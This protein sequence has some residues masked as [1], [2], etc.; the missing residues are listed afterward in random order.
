VLAQVQEDV[1]AKDSTDSQTDMLMIRPSSSNTLM[2]VA[3][4]SSVRN[5]HTKPGAASAIALTSSSW[6]TNPASAGN[7]AGRPAGRC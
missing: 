5:R 6:F 4:L 7:P 2:A 3:L 1:L